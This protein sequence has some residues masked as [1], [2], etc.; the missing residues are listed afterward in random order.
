VARARASM[1]L[2]FCPCALPAPPRQFLA[3][4]ECVHPLSLFRC[5]RAHSLSSFFCGGRTLPPHHRHSP[6]CSHHGCRLRRPAEL[7]PRLSGQCRT[8]NRERARV[9]SASC[10]FFFRAAAFSTLPLPT[11]LAV[12]STGHCRQSSGLAWATARRWKDESRHSH[13]GRRSRSQQ[14]RR[15]AG[16]HGSRRPRS[17]RGRP[18][19]RSRLLGPVPGRGYAR[20]GEGE[21]GGKGGVEV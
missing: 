5:V 3:E 2:F 18:G 13:H 16:A 4:F 19:P 15:A 11:S 20:P 8:E 17:C 6:S 7:G 10:C 21:G 1:L 12:P 14:R 9:S